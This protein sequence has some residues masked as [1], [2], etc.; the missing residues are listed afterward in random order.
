MIDPT[1]ER[2]LQELNLVNVCTEILYD[3][4]NELYMNMRFLDVSLSSLDFAAD[5]GCRG[6]GTDGFVIY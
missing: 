2:Q 4:R 5:T 1:R 3:A 6:L